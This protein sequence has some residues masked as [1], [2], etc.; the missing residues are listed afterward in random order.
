MRHRRRGRLVVAAGLLHGLL[1]AVRVRRGGSGAGVRGELLGRPAREVEVHGRGFEQVVGDFVLV[2]DGADDVRAD[3]ALV[4]EGFHAAPDAGP[5]ADLQLALA[6]DGVAELVVLG[7]VGVDPLLDLDGAGA[8][9][10]L[11]G[12]VRGLGGDVADLANEGDL[13]DLGAFDGEF[14][15][16]V[17][18]GGGED[19]EDGEGAE[20]VFAVGALEED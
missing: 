7:G 17:R 3:V 11:V 12:H 15:V 19:L 4:V 18:L 14:G 20:G 6:G 10:E 16:G 9:V 8:V 13:R 1:L 2:V 5:L